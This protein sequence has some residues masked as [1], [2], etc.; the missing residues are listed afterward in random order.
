MT[1]KNLTNPFEIFIPRR[2]KVLMPP[3]IRQNVTLL[4]NKSKFKLHYINL[5][6]NSNLSTSL[7]I[8]FESENRNLSYLI[9][10][11][12]SGIP[13]LKINLIDEWKLVCPE[14][15]FIIDGNDCNEIDLF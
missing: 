3:M 11:R 14:G 1:I 4:S 12:F 10:V 9:I 15:Y 6:H 7:H 13:N 8:D 5:T 2:T